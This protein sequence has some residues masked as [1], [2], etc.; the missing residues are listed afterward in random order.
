MSDKK[1]Q[2]TEESS[3][4]NKNDVM[5]ALN[6][7][8]APPNQES[9]EEMKVEEAETKTESQTDEKSKVEESPIE[10]D[11][12]EA[13]WLIENKF[14]DTEE[15]RQ[16]L[17]ES[18]KNM[19]SLKDKAEG[20]LKNQES[21]YER[22]KQLD[23]FLKENPKVVDTLQK[24][25]QNTSKKANSAPEKPED[26]DILDEQI[27]GSNSQKWRKDHDEWLIKQGASQAMQYVD[28]IRQKDAETQ[29][30]QAEV[31]QLKNMGMQDDEIQSFYGWMDN[32]DNVTIENKVKV[33][34][35]LNGGQ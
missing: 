4:D 24:E 20:S 16:K 32:P 13:N 15:G 7:F 12:A 14:R 19:Q 22:L 27:D 9:S 18:Y 28:D 3:T 29:A 31:N 6:D 25:V 17:A 33:Y 5:D 26:Y 8:N 1:V 10:S 11:K 23:Q 30:F 2:K 21:E 35:I 34:K